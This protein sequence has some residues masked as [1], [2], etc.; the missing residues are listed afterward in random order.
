[1]KKVLFPLLF[2]FCISSLFAQDPGYTGPAKMPLKNFWS[3]IEKLKAG[4]GTSSSV[5]NAERMLQQVKEKDP[6]YNTTA[7]EAESSQRSRRQKRSQ[8]KGRGRKKLL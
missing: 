1:M 8:N 4:T 2:L 6:S 3:H 7:L 5:N